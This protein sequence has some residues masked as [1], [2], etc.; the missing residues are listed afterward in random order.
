MEGQTAKRVA[1]AKKKLEQAK[2]K[3]F[4]D[5]IVDPDSY[6]QTIENMFHLSFLV[7]N[8]MYVTKPFSFDRTCLLR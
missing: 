4:F 7:R 6:S 5:Y 8:G 3:G 1:I 2:R